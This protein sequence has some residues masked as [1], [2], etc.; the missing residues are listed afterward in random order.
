MYSFHKKF[1]NCGNKEKKLEEADCKMLQIKF[2][3]SYASCT[4]RQN[5]ALVR[6]HTDLYP[7]ALYCPSH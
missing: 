1:T 2:Y 6:I 4:V 5:S 3:E 7:Q